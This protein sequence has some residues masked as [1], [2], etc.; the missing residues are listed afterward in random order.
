MSQPQ[1]AS[2]YGNE[3]NIGLPPHA[4][5]KLLYDYRCYSRLSEGASMN[6]ELEPGTSLSNY[7]R[8]YFSRVGEVSEADA[9]EGLNGVETLLEAKMET[10]FAEVCQDLNSVMKFNY[11]QACRM[12]KRWDDFSKAMEWG[13]TGWMDRRTSVFGY[14][15]L[16]ASAHPNNILGSVAAPLVVPMDRDRVGTEVTLSTVV[17]QLHRRMNAAG[18]MCQPGDFK[19]FVPIEGYSA[20][21]FEQKNL[22]VCCGLDNSLI[23]GKAYMVDGFT[24]IPDIWVPI[25]GYDTAGVPIYYVIMERPDE[26]YFPIDICRVKWEERGNDY[27]LYTTGFFGFKVANPKAVAVAVV[28]FV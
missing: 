2:G 9:D 20:A 19:V 10:D 22:N 8:A 14:I 23:T 18:A 6:F 7:S 4:A 15:K 24:L 16:A 11:S 1:H 26:V 28:K 25:A 5:T 17:R 13:V 21:T 3:L 12:G 27:Y